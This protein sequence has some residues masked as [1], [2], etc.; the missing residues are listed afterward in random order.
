MTE[1]ITFSRRARYSYA[2]VISVFASGIIAFTLAFVVYHLTLWIIGSVDTPGSVV[3]MREIPGPFSGW[4][5][6]AVWF[7]AAFFVLGLPK[8]LIKAHRDPH[9]PQRAPKATK[10]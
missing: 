3:F 6:F 2:L 7:W 9:Y 10:R 4:L 8:E 5:N 1:L